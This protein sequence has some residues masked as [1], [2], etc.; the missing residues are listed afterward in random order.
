MAAITGREIIVAIAKAAT[1]RTPV[2]LG[3]GNGILVTEIG[4]DPQ[5]DMLKDDSLGQM[6]ITHIDKGKTTVQGTL[7]GFM[8]YDGLDLPLGLVMGACGTPAQQ[9]ATIAYAND[10]TIADNNDGQFATMAVLKQTDKVWEWPSVKFYSITIEGEMNGVVTFSMEFM[11]NLCVW[12]SVV[13]TAGTM[14]TVTCP[15]NGNRL[16]LKDNVYFRMND[17]SG[18]ALSSSNNIYPTKFKFAFKRPMPNVDY[19]IG[20]DGIAEPSQEGFPECTLEL[21]FPRYD[22]VNHAYFEDWDEM[23]DKKIDIMFTGALIAS[24]YYRQFRIQAPCAQVTNGQA[25][26]SGPGRIPASITLE[27]KGCDTAPTGM[28]G[29]IKPFQISVQN[30]K[31]TSVLTAVKTL[32]S[33]VVTP[34]DSTTAED[35]TVQFTAT[36]HYSDSTTANITDAVAWSSTDITK[37]TIDG[38]GL[39]STVDGVSSG[40]ST[41]V[42]TQGGISGETTLA[43]TT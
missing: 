40:T 33:I 18:S 19:E 22:A 10:F 8:R 12:D 24:T 27:L 13:N 38:T 42:A 43:Y 16:I 6:Y 23:T 21:T 2:A 7:K 36:G 14:D 1:W 34:D 28:T 3:A 9:G 20:Q 11:C 17:A 32:T 25:A 5:F 37:F 26:I 41:I 15:E 31:S 39:A 35:T 29:I 4:G 30:T